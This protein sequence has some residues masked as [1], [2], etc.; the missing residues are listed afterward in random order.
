MLQRLLNLIFELFAVDGTTASTGSGR[1]ACLNHEV[2]DDTV[3]DDVIVVASLG[4]SCKVL[5]SF[6]RM[7]GVKL[8]CDD[9]HRCLE[10]YI[11]CHRYVK[12]SVSCFCCETL[13]YLGT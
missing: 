6:G 5:A 3:E 1:I 9:S 8:D 7:V 12:A 13:R 2:W 4:E 10:R 11:C